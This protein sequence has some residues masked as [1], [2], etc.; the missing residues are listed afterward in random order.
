MND[1]TINPIASLGSQSISK[2]PSY[3]IFLNEEKSSKKLGESLKFI[4]FDKPELLT[5]F[6]QV[7]G[8]FSNLSED[9]ISKNFIEL[10]TSTAKDLILEVMFPCHKISYMRSL[11]FKQK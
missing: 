2:K 6:V 1:I 3:L 11:V 5:G 9:E 7:K 10:L 8:F 4:T